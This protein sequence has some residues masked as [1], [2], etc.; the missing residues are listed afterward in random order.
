MK[1][2]IKLPDREFKA[3]SAVKKLF[4]AGSYVHS[5]LLYNAGLEIPLSADGRYVISHTSRYSIY[6]FW[7]CLS[8]NS[9]Q[10]QKV[11]E[12]FDNIQDKNIFY[13]L[14]ET[15]PT[16]PD[17]YLRAGIFFLLNKY[18][19]TGYVSRGEFDP[20]SYNPLALANLRRISFENFM[21]TYNKEQDLI[22]NMKDIKARCDYIFVPVGDFSLNYLKN[23]EGDLNGLAYDQTFVDTQGLRQFLTET[24]K[25]TAY[26]YHYS[27]SVVKFFKDQKLHFIDKWGRL[28]D[29]EN[30]AKE[31]IVANF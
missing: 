27:R 29:D 15:L 26:L 23:K 24:S 16:Y 12:H 4:P 11:I 30:K 7:T 14:Q 9:E 28:T 1:T 19:K 13:L 3:L 22:E 31:V 2:P 6:E 10:V 21:V 8:L 17:P 20:N 5:F 25:N 18:S